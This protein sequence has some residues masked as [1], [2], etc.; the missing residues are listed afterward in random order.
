MDDPIGSM[1]I[2]IETDGFMFYTKVCPTSLDAQRVSQ[3]C[4]EPR[5]VKHWRIAHFDGADKTRRTV[6][7]RLCNSLA[8][9]FKSMKRVVFM[10]SA[11]SP[12]KFPAVRNRYGS[13]LPKVG[14]SKLMGHTLDGCLQSRCL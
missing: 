2:E 10:L 8:K 5:R 1:V 11:V 4:F 9:I 6:P 13:L 14:A 7:F 3:I 12:L